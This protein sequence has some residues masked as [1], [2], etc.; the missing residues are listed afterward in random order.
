VT[1]PLPLCPGPPDKHEILLDK[2]PHSA[3]HSLDDSRKR[4]LVDLGLQLVLLFMFHGIDE[5]LAIEPHVA[6]LML[7]IL[8]AL[9]NLKSESDIGIHLH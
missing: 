2:E 6:Y 4:S 5:E 8:G 1:C 3:P 7:S 9:L